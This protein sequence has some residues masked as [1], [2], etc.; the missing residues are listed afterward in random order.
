MIFYSYINSERLSSINSNT[1]QIIVK[2]NKLIYI[3]NDDDDNQLHI[4]DLN[5]F[6]DQSVSIDS[7]T[8]IKNKMLLSLNEE[9]F[10]LFGYKNNENS[11]LYKIYNI[12]NSYE[13]SIKHGSFGL[14]NYN[15]KIK[16]IILNENQYFLYFIY[17]NYLNIYRLNSVNNSFLLFQKQISRSNLG[18]NTIECDSFNNETILC[19][20]SLI[21]SEN[22]YFNQLYFL[23]VKWE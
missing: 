16:I 23:S 10:I 13:K 22:I 7:E 2:Q 6:E 14:N 11:F 3:T 4:H 5:S 19:V 1:T 21:D 12:S 8:E 15:T 17:F 20:Y 18:L 9:H